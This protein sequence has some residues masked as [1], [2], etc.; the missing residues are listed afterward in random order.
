MRRAAPNHMTHRHVA[1]SAL[2]LSAL[3]CL[4]FLRTVGAA[5]KDLLDAVR[6]ADL[7]TVRTLLA[8]NADANAR[9]DIGATA[10]MH[11]AAFSSI[12]CMRALLDKRADV[13]AS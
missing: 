10:L 2:G 6:N 11:A 12:D 9:D 1:T 5:D 13:N 7:A 4:V 3:C 8:S